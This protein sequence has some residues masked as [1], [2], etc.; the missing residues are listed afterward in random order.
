MAQLKKNL[1]ALLKLGIAIFIFYLILSQI[2]IK[3]VLST[4]TLK[5]IHI[6]LFSF[7]A[8]LIAF[9]FF[10][11][12]RF[13]MLVRGI[14]K[15][16]SKS[17]KLTFIGYFFN[18]FLPTNIG[19]DGIKVFYLKKESKGESIGNVISYVFAERF[20]GFAT[21]FIIWVLYT[22]CYFQT[23]ALLVN[24]INQLVKLDLKKVIAV[25][26]LAII[27]IIALVLFF[28]YSKT[29]IGKRITHFWIDF[30]DKLN[31]I[32]RRQY[33]FTILHSIF[34]HLFR[35]VAFYLGL[36]YFGVQI[37]PVHIIFLLFLSTFIGFL[38]ISVG[39]LGTLEAAIVLS[40]VF[41][42]IQEEIALALALYYRLVIIFFSAIGGVIYLSFRTKD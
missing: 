41:F 2:E 38:P 14:T 33:Y 5:N 21:I 39:A 9:G 18:N 13:H 30:R 20:V 27:I 34:F 26:L 12:Y 36:L 11:S 7:V 15:S 40:L 31:D 23:F 37:D 1:I 28:I 8:F 10:F 35:G 16:F 22:L 3:E 42:D 25:L 24:D 32:T 4:F 6:L 17:F 29:A 19:G